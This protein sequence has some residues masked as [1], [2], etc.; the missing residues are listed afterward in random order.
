MAGTVGFTWSYTG[1]GISASGAFLAG[2]TA[3]PGQYAIT[4]IGGQRNGSTITALDATFGSPDQLLFYPATDLGLPLSPTQLDV[5][6]FSFDIG[7]AAYNI[8][9]SAARTTVVE[10]NGGPAIVFNAVPAS[11]VPFAWNYT[12]AGI[13]A[14]GTFVTVALPTPGEYEIMSITGE[15]NGSPITAFDTTFGTPDEL[16]YYPATDLGL[17][18]SPTQLDVNGFSFDIGAAAYNIFTSAA[19]TTVVES[20]GG[21]AIVFDAFPVPEPSCQLL[22]GILFAGAAV[23]RARKVRASR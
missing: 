12:G 13:S 11:V 5:N 17:P 18:L 9:T 20:N 23:I 10:S 1:S 15:R 8:F 3:T 16:L 21:P 14:D 22:L 6:G 7:A 19:R 4:A 2:T